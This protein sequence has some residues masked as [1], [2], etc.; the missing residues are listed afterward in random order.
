[1]TLN[2]FC[3]LFQLPF[4]GSEIIFLLAVYLHVQPTGNYVQQYCKMLE[5][6]A[7]KYQSRSPG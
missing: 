2:L 6:I 4:Q 5:I 1:M 3:S 7:I